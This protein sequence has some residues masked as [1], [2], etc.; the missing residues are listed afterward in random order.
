[1]YVNFLKDIIELLRLAF[2]SFDP[3]R[4]TFVCK[5]FSRHCH[6]PHVCFMSCCEACGKHFC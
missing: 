1:M 5:S 2:P 6:A 3:Q 4:N